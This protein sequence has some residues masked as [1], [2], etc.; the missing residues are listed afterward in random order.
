MIVRVLFL[1]L[2]LGLVACNNDGSDTPH[3]AANSFATSDTDQLGGPAPTAT[4]VAQ[5][6]P[7][8]VSGDVV[9]TTLPDPQAAARSD[10]D[11][12]VKAG[13]RDDAAAVLR[14]VGLDE[15]AYALY[16]PPDYAFYLKENPAVTTP[17]VNER[18]SV[19]RH[20]M[21][22]NGKTVWL[23]ARAGHLIAWSPKDADGKK[24]PQA[25][26]FYMAYTRDDLPAEKRP[27][28]F[29]FNGGAGYAS[30]FLHM[31]SFAP[32]RV[33]IDSPNLSRKAADLKFPV[34]DNEETLLDQSDL[35]FVD[36]VGSGFSRP[37][38]PFGNEFYSYGGDAA[39]T[40]DIV[41]SYSNK[42]NRQSSPKYL[43][44]ESAGAA[45]IAAAGRLLVDAG[46]K[47]FDPDPSG[48]PT[49]VLSGLVLFSPGFGDDPSL[50]EDQQF[51]VKHYSDNPVWGMI[52]RYFRK[53]EERWHRESSID[54]YA[55]YL[56][57]LSERLMPFYKLRWDMLGTDRSPDEKTLK[58]I[59]PLLAELRGMTGKEVGWGKL[60]RSWLTSI[61]PA[62]RNTQ[63]DTRWL[64]D[65]YE[66]DS[67]TDKLLL[68]EIGHHLKT[69]MN[70]FS[71]ERSDSPPVPEPTGP[72]ILDAR[73]ME[74]SFTEY[75]PGY[76][77][78]CGCDYKDD[79]PVQGVPDLR[80]LLN[81][82]PTVKAIVLQGYYDSATPFYTTEL[83][84]RF[85]G[86]DKQIPVKVFEGGH[87][88]Y[89]SEAAL[90]PM[91]TT[92]DAFY[93]APAPARAPATN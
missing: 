11:A 74:K 65:D 83:K 44:G 28:T 52:D 32:K 55:D 86:L 62:N 25:S 75:D 80:D 93:T 14:G 58:E 70:Y 60:T 5:G 71:K 63:Y 40:R 69:Y 2:L 42:Y 21:T 76:R 16:A 31:G 4:T 67:V 37:I 19:K 45:R 7:V 15:E 48:K 91:K 77:G 79:V 90:K 87:M 89:L 33:K 85:G 73:F 50:N 22:I 64:A 17:N 66:P 56:R 30:F 24:K 68:Y 78:H 54:E 36:P 35:V 12:L 53:P 41:T 6:V 92:L 47:D 13:K 8:P 23:T 84:I 26:I 29:F 20:N 46:T 39:I 51:A 72:R 61:P 3:A 10:A 34:I 59:E 1:A 57:Q 38:E 88:M 18:T 81:K 82:D 49:D 43:F 9:P 27:V